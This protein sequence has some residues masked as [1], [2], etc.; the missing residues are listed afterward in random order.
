VTGLLV[1][2]LSVDRMA[3]ALREAASRAWDTRAIRQ[4]AEQFSREAF[5]RGVAQAADE[6][7]AEASPRSW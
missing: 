6:L 7:M 5:T 3:A 1:P 2:D 4:H